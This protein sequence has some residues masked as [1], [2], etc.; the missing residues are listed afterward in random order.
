MSKAGRKERLEKYQNIT[1]GD[2]VY[3]YKMDIALTKVI[4]DEVY[5]EV[6]E[7]VKANPKQ[8][9]MKKDH[10]KHAGH[11]IFPVTWK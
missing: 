11:I 1:T 9:W 3:G 10:L 6:V 4:D 8:C 2:V 5:M 7:S